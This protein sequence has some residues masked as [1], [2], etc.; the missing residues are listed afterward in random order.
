MHAHGFDLPKA[1][2]YPGS[3]ESLLDIAGDVDGDIERPLR[4][5]GCQ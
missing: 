1:V 3:L 4:P 2:T 5:A